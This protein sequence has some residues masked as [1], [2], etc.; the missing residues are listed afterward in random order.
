MAVAYITEYHGLAMNNLAHMAL[1]PAIAAQ[2]VA[3]GAEAKSAAFNSETRYIRVHVDAICSVKI[4]LAPTATT[5]DARL[6]ASQTEY[7][8]V[9]PGDKISVISNT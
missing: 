1:E 5:T 6:A 9:K 4:G 7:F 3:I 8:G 2:V